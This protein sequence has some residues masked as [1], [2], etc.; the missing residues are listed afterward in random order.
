MDDLLRPRPPVAGVILAGG[1]ARRLGG[2]DKGNRLVGGR[3][4]LDRVIETLRPQVA[5]LMLNANG[6]TERFAE[7]GLEIRPDGAEGAGPLAGLLAGL[8]WAAEAGY[9]WLLSVLTDTPFLPADL[10]LRLAA[11]AVDGPAIARSGG[12]RH[13]VIGLWPTTL[14]NP[15]RDHLLGQGWLKADLWAKHCGAIAVDW[16]DEPLDPFFNVNTAED[17]A[18]AEAL[19]ELRPIR[20]GAVVLPPGLDGYAL[21]ANFAAEL[22]RQGV[23][24]GGLLQ[25]G[26]KSQGTPPAE[27]MM[28]ALDSGERFPIMQKLGPGGSCAADTQEIAAAAMALR[29]AIDQRKELI[30]VNKFGSLEAEG[31]GLADEMMAAMAEGLPLLTTVASSRL[32]AWLDTCGGLCELL[33]AD[34]EALWRWWNK[35]K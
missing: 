26:S 33:P 17:Q 27:V 16:P 4:I 15:L 11:Q 30:L 9:P 31:G 24:L 21:L 3:P 35:T 10:L 25:Q 12:R 8:N 5:A 18:R 2:G 29:R 23:L 1:M 32:E 14:A 22:G 34:A 6:E 7:L 19:A 13:P 20:A 28:L